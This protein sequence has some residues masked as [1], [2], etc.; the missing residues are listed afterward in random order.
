MT[1][2]ILNSIDEKHKLYHTF[3][4]SKS[5]SAKEISYRN[6]LSHQ[7]LLK[8]VIASAKEFSMKRDFE[9]CSGGFAI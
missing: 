2:A 1:Q 3:L 7:L 6:F 4:K 5:D 8:K 9:V